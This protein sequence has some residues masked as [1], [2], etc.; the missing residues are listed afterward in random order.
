MNDQLEPQ[1]IFE[2]EF[3]AL[4][5]NIKQVLSAPE[6]VDALEGLGKKFN[7]HLDQLDDLFEEVGLVLLG[8]SR[9]VNFTENLQK[10]LGLPRE[11]INAIAQEI[12]IKIFQPIRESLKEVHGDKE[13]ELSKELASEKVEPI[14][15]T[16]IQTTPEQTSTETKETL[17]NFGIEEIH[18]GPQLE[19]P[20]EIPDNLPIDRADL[21]AEIERPSISSGALSQRE[22]APAPINQSIPT[23]KVQPGLVR[24]TP[25][26][27]FANKLS[28]TVS[29]PSEKIDMSK[30]AISRPAS[31]PY[32]VDP[33][34]EPIE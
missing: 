14:I 34:R 1:D 9:P 25:S 4:P 13:G 29:V 19:S 15:T 27:I 8:I 33:Y 5:D 11:Q 26:D 18:E 7:I 23:P 22:I 3:D 17:K 6:T 24:D 32:K 20:S 12:N 21:L 16:V 28:E 30:D 10:K 2:G 31:A